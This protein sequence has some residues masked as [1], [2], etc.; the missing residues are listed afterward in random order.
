MLVFGVVFIGVALASSRW[1]PIIGIGA[2][3]VLIGVARLLLP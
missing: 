1:T 2:L 3:L